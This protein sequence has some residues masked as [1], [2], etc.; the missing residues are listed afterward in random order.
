MQ[1]GAEI[2][3]LENAMNEVKTI[4]KEDN[5]IV[6]QVNKIQN[7]T[8]SGRDVLKSVEMGEKLTQKPSDDFFG[9]PISVESLFESPQEN[10]DSSR[11]IIGLNQDLNE[12]VDG[13]KCP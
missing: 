4:F 11:N 10:G 2:T 1:E 8:D 3:Q 13:K 6:K 5:E 12:A 9:L 7:D